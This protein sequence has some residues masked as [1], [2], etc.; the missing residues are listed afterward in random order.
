MRRRWLKAV[1]TVGMILLMALVFAPARQARAEAIQEAWTA[2]CQKSIL[3]YNSVGANTEADSKKRALLSRNLNEQSVFITNQGQTDGAIVFYSNHKTSR[4][5]VDSKKCIGHLLTG[6]N[7][8]FT[9][10][11]VNNSV[12]SRPA[13]LAK[14]ALKL[15]YFQGNM[16]EWITGIDTYKSIT[17]GEVWKGIRVDLLAGNDS[18]EKVFIIAAG[19]DPA[20]I[21]ISIDRG[22]LRINDEKEL[23]VRGADGNA[24]FSKPVAWQQTEE[25]KEEV[26]VSYRVIDD[27][28]YGFSLG[29]YDRTRELTIDPLLY[30]TLLG[31]TNHD[32]I[33]V[34]KVNDDYIY[35]M[36]QTKSTGFP[37]V[38]GS[39]YE[40]HAGGWDI[41]VSKF[42]KDLSTLHASTF[43]GGSGD[44]ANGEGGLEIQD[45]E[46]DGAGNIYISGNTA[47]SDFPVTADA[48]DSTY[49]GGIDAF[50]LKLDGSLT[51]LLSSSYY[52]GS[53]DDG[54]RPIKLDSEGNVY[55]AG[56][57]KSSDLPMSPSSNTGQ[58]STDKEAGYYTGSISA[59]LSPADSGADVYYTIDGSNPGTSSTLYTGPVEI[60]DSATLKAVAYKNGMAGIISLFDYRLGAGVAE[61]V[62]APTADIAPGIYAASQTIT[63][64]CETAGASIYYT[65]G[66]ALPT[67]SSTLYSAPIEITGDTLVTAVAYNEEGEKSLISG[68][69]YIIHEPG[70]DSTFNNATDAFI[71]RFSPDLG[72]LKAATYFGS[73]GGTNT[74]QADVI[75]KL[76]INSAG[77]VYAGGYCRKSNDGGVF[78]VTDDAYHVNS[79]YGL[80]AFIARLSGDLKDLKQCGLFDPMTS[81]DGVGRSDCGG[82]DIDDDGN[83]FFVNNFSA[84]ID[85]SYWDYIYLLKFP[86]DLNADNTVLRSLGKR[87]GYAYDMKIGPDGDIYVAG[88]TFG[89]SLIPYYL[90]HDD[91]YVSEISGV[92]TTQYYYDAFVAKFTSDIEEITTTDWETTSE[93]VA[94]FQGAAQADAVAGE[95]AED[96]INIGRSLDFGADGNVYLA[97][98]SNAAD[99]PVT[100]GA[101]DTTHSNGWDGFIAVLTPDLAQ[102]Q[103]FDYETTI[104]TD[105]GE[106]QGGQKIPVTLTVKNN[107]PDAPGS[108][109]VVLTVTPVEAVDKIEVDSIGAGDSCSVSG[110]QVTVNL[111]GLE[112]DTPRE[113]G[114]GITTKSSYAGTLAFDSTVTPVGG[115]D[116]DSGNN[117]A[118]Q[119]ITVLEQE[120]QEETCDVYV[121]NT[122]EE[123]SDGQY[124]NTITWGNK[125]TAMALNT[126]LVDTLDPK[127]VFV[128]AEPEGYVYDTEERTVTWDLSSVATGAESTD[129]KVTSEP[130]SGAAGG[131]SLSD[132]VKI[133]SDTPDADTTNNTTEK[134]FGGVV[135]VKVSGNDT[136][137]IERDFTYYVLITNNDSKTRKIKATVPIPNYTK[138]SS[139][140]FKF[141]ETEDP[142]SIS[143]NDS[144]N[145][146]TWENS[147]GLQPGQSVELYVGVIP[148]EWNEENGFKLKCVANASDTNSGET[149]KGSYENKILRPDLKVYSNVSKDGLGNF[150]IKL[151]KGDVETG[152]DEYIVYVKNV[153]D[154]YTRGTIDSTSSSAK[155]FELNINLSGAT[156]ENV[157]ITGVNLWRFNADDSSDSELKHTLFSDDGFKY[158]AEYY[159]MAPGSFYKFCVELQTVG[160]NDAVT[161]G[162]I[163]IN[164]EVVYYS[165]DWM[166]ADLDTSNN[167]SQGTINFISFNPVRNY[168]GYYDPGLGKYTFHLDLNYQFKSTASTRASTGPYTITH[169][170]ENI[171][172]YNGDNLSGDSSPAMTYSE[173]GNENTCAKY[174]SVKGIL[175]G[176]AASVTTKALCDGDTLDTTKKVTTHLQFYDAGSGASPYDRSHTFSYEDAVAIDEFAPLITYPENGEMFGVNPALNNTITIKGKAIPN[177]QVRIFNGSGQTASSLVT[178]DAGGTFE[179]S[180]RTGNIARA[181]GRMGVQFYAASYLQDETAKKYSKIVDLTEPY[182]EWCPQRTTWSAK[183]G[184]KNYTFKFREGDAG[185]LSTT[186]WEIPGV[187]GMTSSVLKLWVG[188]EKPDKVWVEADG[189]EYN[190]VSVSGHY[191]SFNIKSA[192]NVAIY[193]ECGEEETSAGPDGNAKETASV[194]TVL[195]D[196][197]GYVFDST[198]GW[199]NV[200]PGA[201]VTCMMYD[202]ANQAWMQWPAELYEEQIN[203]QTVGDDGYF[204]FFT[205]P[206]AYRLVVENPSPYQK[207][208][209]PDLT[210]IN[211]IV[212][213]NIPYVPLPSG[214]ASVVVS[215]YAAALMDEYGVDASSLT[216]QAGQVIEWIARAAEDATADELA[217]LIK[218]P[219]IRIQSLLDPETDRKGFDS[220]LLRP[221]YSYCYRFDYPGT[222]TYYYVNGSAAR[223][224]TVV[225]E[226][227]TS[228]DTSSPTAPSGLVGSLNSISN[229]NLSWIGSTDDT[230]VTSYQIFRRTLPGGEYSQ[231]GTAAAN[232]YTDSGLAYTTAYEYYVVAVDAAGNLSH[233]SDPVE[234]TTGG[235][236]GGGRG[237]VSSTG[238]AIGTSGGTITHDGLTIVIPANAVKNKIIVRIEKT[239][240]TDL[241][242]LLDALIVSE[243][244]DINKDKS[245]DFEKA[246]T[247]TLSFDN[248]KVA[249]GKYELAICW[250]DISSNKWVKLDNIE[251]DFTNAKISGEVNHFTEFAV[252]ATPQEGLNTTQTTEFTDIS[253]HWARASIQRLAQAKVISGYP[254]HTYRPD[255]RISRAEFTVILVKALKLVPTNGRIFDDTAQ[256]WAKNSIATAQ[257]YG[258]VNGYS[259][260]E[261]GPDEKITREQM[262]VMITKAANLQAAADGKVFAD[263]DS[264]ADWAKDSIAAVSARGLMNGY[265][266]GNFKPQANATRAETA[267]VLDLLMQGLQAE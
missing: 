9:E 5:T 73:A 80:C 27:R 96:A 17:L 84:E 254:D 210:V 144:T 197:D 146:V 139:S 264:I 218:N 42:S 28:T 105:E 156:K 114:I 216:L 265:P 90:L 184:G 213:Q 18:A 43:I 131:S 74:T 15:N 253:G 53:G 152:I 102:N 46:I 117:T 86:A 118:S 2:S 85:A 237:T 89:N 34:V 83:I 108:A 112:I 44:E 51:Q 132:T 179:V 208:I 37:T 227:G 1:L 163:N 142:G 243:V 123:N 76:D 60:A 137:Y 4:V 220:G 233:A 67:P 21:L 56:W 48:Y 206:G 185:R 249:P 47:S 198:Q 261:F 215:V 91:S 176:R 203:P 99:Y 183:V 258:I 111:G 214:D 231:V 259:S 154:G 113:T 150:N 242:E 66:G 72:V 199:G 211:E 140:A 26:E 110:N 204:A 103:T 234:A 32:K 209:S 212:H 239:D 162:E 38:A 11:F 54:A 6:K 45:M 119:V 55:I 267:R 256:H 260:T 187:M 222:Y 224:G 87:G 226:G 241:P 192:H 59:T 50:V 79:N 41:F 92:A 190:P 155:G 100:E 19:A 149:W 221:G 69:S 195:I 127:T 14:A 133:S 7:T 97:G 115:T 106:P 191:Y 228:A 219:V 88:R 170:M 94:V 173:S 33:H 82:L 235:S 136:C 174:S 52:G 138:Y 240:K 8:A 13:G 49:N 266:D 63:L 70:Y 157:K 109:R 207:W 36:G 75:Q 141:L 104:E 130:E 29:A 134:S 159:P 120:E 65:L 95:S 181:D 147:S 153:G 81:N 78:P 246:V 23:V 257:A 165:A 194:G 30:S 126:K 24:R 193:I 188:C 68:F 12:T 177:S 22:S 223:T 121:D 58:V 201:T 20:Q 175:S 171:T 238:T 35:V 164:A 189:V 186:N 200:V 178:A 244:F 166:E 128:S 129:Y 151:E 77:E 250:F 248:S 245:G 172:K 168:T 202:E 122:I 16:N 148:L 252:I 205:P 40:N 31:D 57:T 116:S 143:Y 247:V 167:E 64:Q 232:S 158:E 180:V 135:K 3:S 62:Y 217:A 107:G 182:H 71:A 161:L 101:Y 61:T 230:G 93:A 10:S 124:E 262:A 39:V 236:S 251:V 98:Q 125:G 255:A 229:I 145:T 169:V 196:P 25:G 263:S 160:Y 225:V